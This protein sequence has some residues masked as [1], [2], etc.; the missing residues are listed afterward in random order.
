MN[1][2]YRHVNYQ[3]PSVTLPPSHLEKTLKYRG[4]NYQSPLS[5]A[6]LDSYRTQLTYR[7]RSY[8]KQNFNN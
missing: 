3:T 6:Q 4:I 8:L 5:I 7:G 2:C 1:L